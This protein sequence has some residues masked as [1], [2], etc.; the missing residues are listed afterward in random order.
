MS[1]GF[2]RVHSFT[3]RLAAPLGYVDI[4]VSGNSFSHSFTTDAAGN[5]PD[6][7]IM[8]PDRELSLVEHGNIRP[9]AVCSLTASKHGWEGLSLEGIQ[10]FDG[11]ITL[12]QLE[13]TPGENDATENVVIPEHLL[14][15]GNGGSGPSPVLDGTTP[16]ILNAVVIPEKITVHLGRPAA[17]ARNVTVSFREYIANVASSEVYPTCDEFI[18]RKMRVRHRMGG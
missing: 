6:I 8:T 12:A 2:L 1:S 15:T 9:Y 7:E 18:F 3:S 17:S 16:A 11:Q 4:T 5:A 13:M 10:I 14:L